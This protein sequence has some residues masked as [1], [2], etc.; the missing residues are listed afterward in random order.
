LIAEQPLS[1]LGMGTTVSV[2]RGI[3]APNQ[4]KGLQALCELH[5]PRIHL[6]VNSQKPPMF[7]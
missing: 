2:M 5:N 4:N 1:R 7:W 3:G 6:V